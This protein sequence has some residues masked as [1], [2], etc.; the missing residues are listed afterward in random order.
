[1]NERRKEQRLSYFDKIKHLT[2]QGGYSLEE[3]EKVCFMLR[4]DTYIDR[5]LDKTHEWQ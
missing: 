5:L 3:L 1:M 2:C 4:L